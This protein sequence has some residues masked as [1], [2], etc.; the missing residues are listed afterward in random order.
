[1]VD[2]SSEVKVTFTVCVVQA[3]NSAGVGPF[4][5][6]SWSQTPMNSPAAVSAVRATSTPQS[7]HLF[8]KEPVSNG[9]RI[10]SYNIDI[11]DQRPLLSVDANTLECNITD[12][13]PETAYK[14]VVLSCAMLF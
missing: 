6:E 7:I 4:S 3:V 8:W 10:L 2:K 11:G 14:S 13:M 12:L 9:S 5:T 1:V